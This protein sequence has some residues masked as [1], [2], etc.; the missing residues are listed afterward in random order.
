MNSNTYVS[1]YIVDFQLL[2][3]REMLAR[4]RIIIKF[5]WYWGH[6]V[7]FNFH[8][9]PFKQAVKLP[10]L[11]YKPHLLKCKGKVTIT[12]DNIWFGMIQLGI[13]RNRLYPNSGFTWIN[14]GGECIFKGKSVSCNGTFIYIMQNGCIEF[15][16]NFYNGPNTRLTSAKKIIFGDNN[17]LGWDTIVTDTSFHRCKKKNGEWRENY[18]DADKTIHLGANNWLAMRCLVLK[19]TRTPDYAIFGA[20]STLNKDYSSYPSYIMMAGNPLE[21]KAQDIWRDPTDKNDLIDH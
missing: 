17:G 18:L 8:Y 12:S 20:N 3:T 21:V 16:K 2:N 19:G 13:F 5:F 9:L 7:Y 15:G 14:E 4:L 10:I 1:G 11:L 6:I